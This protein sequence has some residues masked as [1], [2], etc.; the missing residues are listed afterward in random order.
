MIENMGVGVDIEQ[1][2][3]FVEKNDSF[4]NK[5]FTDEELK[6]CFSKTYHAQHLAVRF[7]GKEAVIKALGSLGKDIKDYKKIEIVNNAK[8][9]P[10]AKLLIPEGDQIKIKIS[11]SHCQD[12]AMAM[13]LVSTIK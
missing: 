9:V 1:I 5:I 3:R 10:L 4:L 2:S 13:V 8:G 7:A 6:Y 11:L 12:K